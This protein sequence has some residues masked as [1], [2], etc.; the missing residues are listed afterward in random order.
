MAPESNVSRP[1]G[2]QYSAH[3]L[4][5]SSFVPPEGSRQ[6]RDLTRARANL[7]YERIPECAR[8][9]K[10]LESSNIKLPTVART[11]HT[12]SARRMPVPLVA[13]KR[14]PRLLFYLAHPSMPTKS[15]P[16]V[17]RRP[18]ASPTTTASG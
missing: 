6:L 11:L 15:A 8:M 3:D 16:L 4:L 14:D 9:E 1:R 18:S 2:A 12:Q 5:R 17:G 10:A 7:V 13:G